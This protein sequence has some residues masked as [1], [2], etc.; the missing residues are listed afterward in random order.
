MGIR[1]V[2]KLFADLWSPVENL[3]SYAKILPTSSALHVQKEND[4]KDTATLLQINEVDIESRDHEA[5]M[6]VICIR[7][8]EADL[9]M[10]TQK[11]K[12]TAGTSRHNSKVSQ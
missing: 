9:K 11:L 3:W 12:G 4:L 10:P 8:L 1:S 2:R 6:N 7:Q 5:H